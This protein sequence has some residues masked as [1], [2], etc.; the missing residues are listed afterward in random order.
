MGFEMAKD[1]V[2]LKAIAEPNT[3]LR[4]LVGS[5]VHG[6]VLDGTDDRDEMGVCIEPRRYVVGFGK[7]EQWVYRSAGEREGRAGARSQAGDLDLTIYSLRKWARLALQGN[8]TV[9]LLLYLPD[10]ALVIR[11]EV[12]QQLQQLA[13]AFASRQAGRRFLGYL[14]AQRQ[15]LVGE[16]GQR[17]VNRAELV[18][19]FGYDTKYAMHMLRLGHQGVEFLETGRLTL[20]MREPVRNHLMDVRR[21]R[22]N[23]AD[24]LAECTDLELRLSALLES[25]PL[26]PGPETDRVESFVMDA[27][28]AAWAARDA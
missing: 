20:P 12:G 11:T 15:R 7:F 21:G 8:P 24:V 22:S 26:P 10:D 19:Q 25:S 2:E 9:L 13:P 14:E 1:D 5:S 23:L 18:E 17:D 27:Y 3:I 6:L 4:G 16:R 28:A